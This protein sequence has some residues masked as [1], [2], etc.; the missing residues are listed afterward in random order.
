[1]TTLP[2]LNGASPIDTSDDNRLTFTA[3][4]TETLSRALDNTPSDFTS[5]DDISWQVEYRVSA[6]PD[7]DTYDLAIRIVNGGTILAAADAGGSF[8]SVASNITNTTDTTSSVTAFSFVNTSADKTTW[9][10]ANI[11]LQQTYTKTKGADNVSIEVDVVSITGNYSA[12]A[13]TFDQSVGGSMT[14]SGA[15]QKQ[16]NKSLD[17]SITATGSLELLIQKVLAASITPSG[18]LATQT[19]VKQ[20][21]AGSITPSGALQKQIALILSGSSAPSGTLQKQVN[22]ILLGSIT[23]SGSLQ[24]RI[25]KVLDG[26]LTP[27]GTIATAV[28]ILVQLAG[29]VVMSGAVVTLFIAG[30]GAVSK[31]LGKILKPILRPILKKIMKSYED[32]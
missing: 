25:E 20:A 1:M 15:L 26:S 21:I 14:P 29:Q 8:A 32:E 6:A 11:E 17:G 30:T 19:V 24:K 5:M 16:V 27:S 12:G 4:L 22:K 2:T 18:D 7:D 3:D 28:V 9:D 13:T 31:F 10:G 23:L